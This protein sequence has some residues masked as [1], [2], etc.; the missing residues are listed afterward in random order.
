MVNLWLYF[1]ANKI[2][3]G[4]CDKAHHTRNGMGQLWVE[5]VDSGG[6]VRMGVWNG[7]GMLLGG[8]E[9]EQVHGEKD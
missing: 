1:E 8:W 9:W 6:G 5:Q 3:C 2:L 7:G 4:M